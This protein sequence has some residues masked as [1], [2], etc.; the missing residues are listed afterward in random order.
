M[1]YET[2]I[3]SNV[4]KYTWVEIPNDLEMYYSDILF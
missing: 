4:E 1:N 3:D 2:I